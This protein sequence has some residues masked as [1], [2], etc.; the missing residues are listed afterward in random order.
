MIT[1]KEIAEQL[2]KE[3]MDWGCTYS[4]KH[5]QEIAMEYDCTPLFYWNWQDGEIERSEKG[6]LRVLGY[7]WKK[8]FEEEA[9]PAPQYAMIEAVPTEEPM[10]A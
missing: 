6:F 1:W 4:Q 5:L 9:D 8:Y 7:A 2:T 10:A 3:L